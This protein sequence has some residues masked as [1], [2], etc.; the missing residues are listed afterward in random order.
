MKVEI[1]CKHDALVEPKKLK[2]HPK[3][4]NKH[5]KEQIERLAKLYEYHGIRHP[6]IVSSRSGY[7]VAGHGRK[8]AAHD[9]GMKE[10]PVVYQDFDS[11]EAEY[12]FIQADNAI[13]LWAE[14]DLSGINSDLPELGPDFDIDML[15]IKNFEIDVADKDFEADEDEVPEARPEPK[16]VQGEVYILGNHRLMCGDSTAITDVERLMNGE[17]AEMCFTDPPYGINYEGGHFHSGDV[18]IKRKREKLANDDSDQIYQD[19]IPVISSFTDGPCYTW[20]ADTKPL[21]LFQSVE[22][23]GQIH[24]LIIWHKINATY[25]AMNAQYKQRHEPCLY[26]KPKRSTLRW[27][28][29]S[30]ER[31]I[32]EMKRDSRNEH[33]PTQ[34]P[35]ELAE[36]AI[37][38]HEAKTVLDLFGGS[39]STLIASEK[40]GRKC[41]MMELDPIYCGVILD[42]WQKFTGKKAQREDGKPWDEIKGE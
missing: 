32:W 7:I 4:R 19:V 23:C 34:K 18:N 6:I 42:R 38:N 14:L 30:D 29:P 1:H 2:V 27:C 10:F 24:S 15:G 33:H 36:R 25:A 26:W 16:V 20:F 41:F 8:A 13:A 40:T 39:G 21:K 28:G 5:S 9:L 37:N 17:K 31:T 12:A 3:N 22:N 11:D 35:V